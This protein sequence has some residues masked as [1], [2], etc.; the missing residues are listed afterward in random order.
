MRKKRTK[1]AS[2]IAAEQAMEALLRRVGYTG[3]TKG[4]RVNEIPNYK[5][6]SNLPPTSDRICAHGP[7]KQ[8]N[9]YTGTLI[10]GVATM[11]KSNAVPVL[12][13]TNDAIDIANMRRN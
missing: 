7:K 4:T 9:T 10:A 5:I 6:Q 3:A 12:R 8:E 2:L 13:N 1:R 11:H